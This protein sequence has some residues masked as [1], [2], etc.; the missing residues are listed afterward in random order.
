MRILAGDIGGT[1]ARLIAVDDAGDEPVEVSTTYL[2]AQHN[3]LVPILE[4]FF[5]EHRLARSFDAVCLAVA[6]PV[7]SGR[8]SITNLP[9]T[10]DVD[11]LGIL[12]GTERVFLINDLTAVAYAVPELE[13][14]DLAIIQ[15]G[16]EDGVPAAPLKAAI[17]GVGT[18]LGASHLVWSGE[19]YLAL[20]SE[21]GHAGFSPET[22]EQEQLLS[23][24]HQRHSHV[25]VE[26]LLSGRGIHT[27][28]QFFRDVKRLPESSHLQKEL[29]QSADPA[30]LITQQALTTDDP[31]CARTVACF[32]EILGAVTGD[33]AL[34]YFPLNAIYLAGGVVPRLKQLLDNRRFIAAMTDKG[35][36]QAHLQRLPVMLVLSSTAGLDGALAYARQAGFSSSEE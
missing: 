11:Q 28:Y 12:L 16:S 13:A 23:W 18:G 24:L 8:A 4:S 20:S 22:A 29:M 14:G 21:A 17:I 6:G 33:I 10:I 36:M 2:C 32:F 9:W 7:F 25:S 34:H 31:L 3:G 5:T 1:H 15:P 35:P 19:R 27:L 26:M 30:P